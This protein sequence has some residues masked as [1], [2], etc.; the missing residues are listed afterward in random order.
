MLTRILVSVELSE[1]RGSFKT[2]PRFIV[3]HKKRICVKDSGACPGFNIKN[4]TEGELCRAVMYSVH[5][6]IRRYGKKRVSNKRAV[7]EV[8][9]ACAAL[10]IRVSTSNRL[11]DAC[12]AVITKNFQRM[13]LAVQ[14]HRG[15]RQALMG[16]CKGLPLPET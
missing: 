11:R 15:R 3:S 10:K 1:A 9:Q 7:D 6:K 16:L 13:V 2:S 5:D 8:R 14:M 4:M 12:T